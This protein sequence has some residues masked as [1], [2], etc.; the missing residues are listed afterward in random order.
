MGTQEQLLI[1]CDQLNA[2]VLSNAVRLF[3]PKRQVVLELAADIPG[4]WSDYEAGYE[5]IRVGY[6]AHSNDPYFQYRNPHK[7]V[8]TALHHVLERVAYI[9]A[10]H[11]VYCAEPELAVALRVA[12]RPLDVR[13]G[14]GHPGGGGVFAR[15]FW[16]TRATLASGLASAPLVSDTGGSE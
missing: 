9:R 6:P 8:K 10:I 3:S 16:L 1:V 15:P 5:W 13:I 2:E 12:L 11:W 4:V 7:G 14:W